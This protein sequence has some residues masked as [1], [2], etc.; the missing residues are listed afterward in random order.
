MSRPNRDEYYKNLLDVVA[1]RGTCLRAKQGAMILRDRRVIVTQYNGALPGQA[2]CTEDTCNSTTPCSNSVHAEEGA[3]VFAA[4]EG[5][6][7]KGTTM[8]C[9]TLPCP[10]CARLIAQA[11]ISELVYTRDY[12]KTEGLSILEM[13]GVKVRKYGR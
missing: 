13:S 11:G 2:H 8:W 3:I 12:R 10:T 7:L 9:T 5:I 4:K 6:P 1:T